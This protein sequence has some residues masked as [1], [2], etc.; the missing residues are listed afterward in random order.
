MKSD[1]KQEILKTIPSN[2]CCSHAFTCVVLNSLASIDIE[3]SSILIKSSHDIIKKFVKIINNFYPEIDLNLWDD[4]LFL[5]GNIFNLLLDSNI[6]ELQDEYLRANYNNFATE[7]DQLT[8][9]KSLFITNGKLYYNADN[10]KKSIGYNLEIIFKDEPLSKI[11]NELLEKFSFKLKQINRQNSTILYTKNSNLICDLLAFLGSITS[12]LEIQNNLA[13]RE[14]RNTTNRQNNCFESNLDKTIIASSEQIKSIKFIIDNYDFDILEES[15]REVALVRLA[16]PDASLKE[17]QTLLDNKIS[18]VA[19]K[20][21]LDKINNL[22]KTL[23]GD[24]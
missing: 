2:S 8:I 16:N 5:N 10:S 13:I 14:I 4:F 7:C 9:L 15:L 23:K 21:R 12:S 19:I 3:N 1:C 22:Y 20:Y 24:N 18:R 6:E 11:C 17:I